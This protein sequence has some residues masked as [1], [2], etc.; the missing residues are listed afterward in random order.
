[1]QKVCHQLKS[2]ERT[3]YEIILMT[4][5]LA[6]TCEKNGFLRENFYIRQKDL[7]EF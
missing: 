6:L 1:M 5:T 4:V 7:T 3:H 2:T